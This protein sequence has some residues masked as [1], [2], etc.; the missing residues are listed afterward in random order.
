M[1][2][3]TVSD[4]KLK[5]TLSREDCLKYGIENTGEEFT[6]I[7][8]RYAVRDIL[9]IAKGE[10]GFS[11]DGEKILAQ[12]YPMPDGSCELFITKL[13][14]VTRQVNEAVRDAQGLSTME[15]KRGTY[16]FSDAGTLVAAARAIYRTGIDCDLYLSDEGVYYISITEELLNGISEFE[17]LIEYGERLK[18]LPTYVIS[19]RGRMLCKKKALDYILHDIK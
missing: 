9:E 13:S 14:G 15:K 3:L 2:F 8:V 16:S 10:C 4:A 18:F 7:D 19:E 17:I 5:V 12:L 6:G 1:E 11:T